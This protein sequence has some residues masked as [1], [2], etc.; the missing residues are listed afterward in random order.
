[1]GGGPRAHGAE[2]LPTIREVRVGD[3]PGAFD[4]KVW[5][6]GALVCGLESVSVL[7][8]LKEG[9]LAAAIWSFP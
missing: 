5:E 8:E 1:V 3:S 6:P 7:G 9:E 4:A 2:E